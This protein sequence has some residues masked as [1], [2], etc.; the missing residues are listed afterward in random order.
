MPPT[1]TTTTATATTAATLAEGHALLTAAAPSSSYKTYSSSINSSKKGGVGGGVVVGRLEGSALA[2]AAASPELAVLKAAVSSKDDAVRLALGGRKG[3]GSGGA[4][5]ALGEG[6]SGGGGG[7]WGRAFT[8]APSTTWQEAVALGR[9]ARE[10]VS[11]SPPPLPLGERGRVNREW[12]AWH[13]SVVG[14]VEGM[15]GVRVG[16]VGAAPSLRS[17]L[18]GHLEAR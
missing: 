4:A 8:K 18:E 10:K 17:C 2:R 6:V 9:K 5:G 14:L 16:V 3:S 1:G 15:D 7:G 12:E 13:A 11:S